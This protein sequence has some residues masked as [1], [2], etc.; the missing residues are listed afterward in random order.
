MS[1][2]QVVL[3]VDDTADV[4]LIINKLLKGKYKTKVAKNGEKALQIAL[5][6]S[7]PDLI[8][9]DVMMPG[10]DGYEVCQRLQE[11]EQGRQIPVVFLTG[12]QSAEERERGLGLGAVDYISKP[13]E[14]AVLFACV[15]RVLES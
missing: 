7:P 2:K 13:V 11:D 4:I 14:P 15:V 5:S 10:M 6:D 9:L 8:L 12:N 1:D 3:I